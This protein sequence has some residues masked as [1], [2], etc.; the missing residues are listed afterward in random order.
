[1]DHNRFKAQYRIAE[2]LDSLPKAEYSDKKKALAATLGV[3]TQ[4]LN[5]LIRGVGDLSG[6]KL[7]LVAEFFAVPVDELYKNRPVDAAAA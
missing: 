4:Q 2:L 3:T 6:T 5:A 7:A 1:M